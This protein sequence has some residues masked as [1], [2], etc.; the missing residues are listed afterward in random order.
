MNIFLFLY[1]FIVL[2]IHSLIYCIIIY[3]IYLFIQ[4]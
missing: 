4:N 2:I 3:W 1:E